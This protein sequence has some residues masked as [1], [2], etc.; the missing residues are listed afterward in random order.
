MKKLVFACLPFLLISGL[1]TAQDCSVEQSRKVQE[2]LDQE[3][4][5]PA[6][7]PL[8][9]KDL[10]KFK[11]LDFFPISE[12]FCVRAKFVRTENE[13]PFLMKTTT[14]RTPEYVKYGEVHFEI[15]GKS[16]RLNVYR[17]IEL[18]K[19]E[20]YKDDL[21]LPFRDAT[22]GEESYEGGRFID[23]KVPQGQWITIDFNT[24]YNPYCAYN[25]NYSCPIVPSENNLE[26]AIKAG[27][28]K[29]H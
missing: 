3:F 11:G 8:K 20:A 14:A 5:N 10:K 13:Q 29:F 18:T 1:A 9:R 17:N 12:A 6:E 2:H 27:V 23:L 16:Y 25:H 26:V 7:S 15:D 19:K 24:A 22:N 21:F 4:A 28:K